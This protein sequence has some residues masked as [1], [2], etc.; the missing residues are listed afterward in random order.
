MSEEDDYRD[1]PRGEN[2]TRS[3]RHWAVWGL[4]LAAIAA[5]YAPF[6]SPF[7]AALLIR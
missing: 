2:W 5:V 6:L 4:L 7:V 1:G 3:P